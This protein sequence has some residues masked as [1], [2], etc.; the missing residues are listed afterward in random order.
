M[1]NAQIVMM[2]IY[3]RRQ[4]ERV[5]WPNC[6][7]DTSSCHREVRTATREWRTASHRPLRSDRPRPAVKAFEGATVRHRIPAEIYRNIK[8]AGARQKCTLF[9]TLL[10]GFGIL[11]SLHSSR[12]LVG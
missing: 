2:P 7:P 11:M 5:P 12:K 10:A 8:K 6:D 3:T 9:V 1:F 4:Y